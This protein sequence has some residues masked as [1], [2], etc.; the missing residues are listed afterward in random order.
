MVILHGG[1]AEEVEAKRLDDGILMPAILARE[2]VERSRRAG[3]GLE[4]VVM[5]W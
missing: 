5:A 1:E 4:V 3:V 2:Y